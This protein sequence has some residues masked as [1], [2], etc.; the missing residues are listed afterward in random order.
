MN[1]PF[2]QKACL[3]SVLVCAVLGF[4]LAGCG[5]GVPIPGTTGNLK[6]LITDKPFPFEFIVEAVVTIERVDVRVA[7]DEGV[8]VDEE[9]ITIADYT[10]DGGKPFNLLE[11]QNGRTDLLADTD[12]PAGHYDQMRLIVT[13]GLVTLVDGRE[14]PL[15]VPSGDR[16]G[17]RLNY[18]FTVGTASQTSLLLD[19]D[20]SQAFTPVP[21][22][23]ADPAKIREFKFSPAIAMRLINMVESASVSGTVYALNFAPLSDVAV[24]VFNGDW[25]EVTTTAT[26]E[27]GTYKVIGL[28]EG[29][30]TF[31][32]SR[33]GF[34]LEYM[35]DVE[36]FAGESLE[37]LDV[38]LLPNE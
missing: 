33:L 8:E 31:Q 34:R 14:F 13:E 7:A 15:S 27:D 30:Y 25:E 1:S 24:T 35:R 38:I 20:L 12:I 2:R 37:E 26:A 21:G 3:A 4:H 17:I 18:E 29:L 32:Y 28:E 22:N 16:A 11:L 6:V 19:V 5:G 36:V 9:F 10:D 23:V